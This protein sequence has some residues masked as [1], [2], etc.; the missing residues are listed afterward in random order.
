MES[1]QEVTQILHQ[2]AA[3]NDQAAGDLLPLVYEDLRKQA[4]QQMALERVNHTLQAT[5]LVHD[6]YLRIMGS[7]HDKKWDSRAHF[8]A[9][10]SSAM[11]RILI[12]HAR[13]R[14]R[15]KRGGDRVQLT[16]IDMEIPDQPISHEQLLELDDALQKLEQSDEQVAELVRLRL[17]AGLSVTESAEILKISRTVAYELWDYAL[18]WFAVELRPSDCPR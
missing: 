6:A 2:V 9:A 1:F 5:A 17:Y 10:A 7:D 18:A 4:S 3:G 8:Y 11:R 13:S 12:D 16:W 15:L 14:S